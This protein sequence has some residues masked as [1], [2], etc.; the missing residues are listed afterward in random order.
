MLFWGHLAPKCIILQLPALTPLGMCFP[1][2]FLWLGL[3]HGYKHGSGWEICHGIRSLNNTRENRLASRPA[4]NSTSSG[5][6][7]S[8][9]LGFHYW[10][11]SCY[12]SL[13]FPLFPSAF[14]LQGYLFFSSLLFFSV[15]FF[16]KPASCFYSFSSPPLASLIIFISNLH[17][18]Q[19]Q[20]ELYVNTWFLLGF[21]S[22]PRCFQE[23]F[24]LAVLFT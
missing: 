12:L 21:C 24:S 7:E 8:S 13:L 6:T 11:F 19:I 23:F 2:T 4:L 22:L 3:E 17:F 1:H 15:F 5:L 10:S 16:C 18:P 20:K 14:L 9:N